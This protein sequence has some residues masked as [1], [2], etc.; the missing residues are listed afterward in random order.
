MG[1]RGPQKKPN[2]L[3]RLEGNPG[4]RPINDKAPEP[5]GRP[6]KPPYVK[7]YAGKV[8]KAIVASMPD[9]LY[10]TCDTSLLAAYC[11]AADLH[12]HSTMMVEKDGGVAFGDGGAPYQNPWVSILNRQAQLLLSL[13]HI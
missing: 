3:K 11:V 8:W 10:S 6:I 1:A 2:K 13:I 4:R 12:R 7:G 9:G 5:T